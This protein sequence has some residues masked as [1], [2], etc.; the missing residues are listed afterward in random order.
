MSKLCNRKLY[1]KKNN[2]KLKH[3]DYKAIK[4]NK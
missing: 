2:Q 1:Y 4:I 3:N